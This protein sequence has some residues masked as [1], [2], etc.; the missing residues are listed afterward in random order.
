M[1]YYLALYRID[2]VLIVFFSY[3]IGCELAGTW[4]Y[5][6]LFIAGALSLISYN[7]IYSFNSWADREIDKFNKPHRPLPAGKI[8]AEYAFIYSIIL[9]LLSCIYPFFIY[10][11]SAVLIIFLLLPVVG[12]LY[13]VGPNF[14][15]TPI[16][17]VFITSSGLVIPFLL[18]YLMNSNDNSL[19]PFFL[20]LLLYCLGIIPLKDIED[21]KGDVK[22]GVRNLFSR[23]QEKLL[24]ICIFILLVNVFFIYIF[25]MTLLIKFFLL[26]FTIS[27]IFFILYF[28]TFKKE[29]QKLYQV[30]INF[31]I[32]LLASCMIFNLF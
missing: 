31:D 8:E 22:Y 14:K 17:A 29:Q 1:V 7:F 11:S 18:G 23:F 12:A 15:R 24:I 19:W 16:L 4:T 3:I 32:A 21:V 26:A 20:T 9:L 2:V 28:L 30:I 13:S 5:E 10:R 27:S 6:E 25:N